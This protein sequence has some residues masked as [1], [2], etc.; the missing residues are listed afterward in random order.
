MLLSIY[1]QP[2]PSPSLPPNCIH[3]SV[4]KVCVSIT[5]LRKSSL[6][7]LLQIYPQNSSH[8]VPPKEFELIKNEF[9][10]L[11]RA[12]KFIFN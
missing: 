6:S 8:I 10:C 12:I 11:K 9:K 4:L 2:S 1:P 7:F 5:A 3:K